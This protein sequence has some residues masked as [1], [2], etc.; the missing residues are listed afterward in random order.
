MTLRDP[1]ASPE[2]DRAK[3]IC[4][5]ISARALEVEAARRLP[6]DLAARLNDTGLPHLSVPAAYGGGGG[7]AMQI[8]RAIE[9]ISAADGA[10]GWCAMIYATTAVV[11]G[12]LPA[13]WARKIY[14]RQNGCLTGGSTPPMGRAVVTDGG[15]R[16]TGR[17]PWG[18]G[19]QNCDWI[20]GGTY[21][22]EDG[23][24]PLLPT[25]EPRVH[26]MYFERS[27]V[28]LHDNW[29]PSGLIGTGSVD[30]EVTDAFVPEGRWIVFGEAKPAIDETLYRFPFF[31]VFAA[32]VSAVPL[33]IAR[34]ALACFVELARDKTPTWQRDTLSK[35]P[36]A[37]ASFGKAEALYN[38]ARNAI[39]GA[40]HEV[41]DHV[42]GGGEAS[43][44]DRRRLRLAAA[45]A[46]EACAQ[47]VD[48]L[49]TAGGGSSI[50]RA[51]PLQRC[52]RDIHVATQHRMVSQANYETAGALKL[53]RERAITMF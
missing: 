28:S 42:A 41:W 33:G 1:Y 30:F 15:V 11:S 44:E 14:S 7:S 47:A 10:V 12:L 13:D 31:G 39:Y 20:T 46:T 6:A 5:E 25:G 29:D 49:Y 21:I 43:L 17:W 40:V 2:L 23:K 16:V 3:L 34:H 36:I 50:H 27:Q 19:A 24:T 45:F 18:S 52:F 32:A 22:L 9:E 53:R 35:H 51:N 26:I 48:I 37:Q 38:G 8:M 4:P